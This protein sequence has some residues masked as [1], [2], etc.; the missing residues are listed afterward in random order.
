VWYAHH[1]ESERNEEIHE[2]LELEHDPI[3]LT[4]LELLSTFEG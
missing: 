2:L 4:G 1:E 3:E